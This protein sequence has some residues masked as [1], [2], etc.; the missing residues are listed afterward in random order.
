MMSKI[1]PT[2]IA[3]DA[4]FSLCML[5]TSPS[6][7]NRKSVSVMQAHKQIMCQRDTSI[8]VEWFYEF[9]CRKDE[10]ALVRLLTSSYAFVRFSPYPDNTVSGHCGCRLN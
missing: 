4:C 8:L 1:T 7:G 3:N 2:V 6:L 9:I 10:S 5:I